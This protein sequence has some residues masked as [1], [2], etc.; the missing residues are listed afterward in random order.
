[1]LDNREDEKMRVNISSRYNSIIIKILGKYNETADGSIRMTQISEKRKY[2][3]T[4]RKFINENFFKE[5]ENL[6][7]LCASYR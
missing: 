1:M 2:C 4:E 5:F 6:C 3:P 7:F